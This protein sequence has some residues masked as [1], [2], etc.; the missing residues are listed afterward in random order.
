[1]FSHSPVHLSHLGS[2]V[3]T[4][5]SGPHSHISASVMVWGWGPRIC[6]SSNSQTMLMLPVQGPC[7]G[8]QSPGRWSLGA[9]WTLLGSFLVKI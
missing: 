4:L 2:S 9:H 6:I 3:G 7:F 8:N 1:M 5:V